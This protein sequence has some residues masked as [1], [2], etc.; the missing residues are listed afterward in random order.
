MTSPDDKDPIRHQSIRGVLSIVVFV[1]LA[2]AVSYESWLLI[3]ALY[4]RWLGG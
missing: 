1:G 4:S 3:R 2:V